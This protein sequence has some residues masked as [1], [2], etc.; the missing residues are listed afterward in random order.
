MATDIVHQW[1]A[2]THLAIHEDHGMTE[3]ARAV[4]Y[5][6]HFKHVIGSM[7]TEVPNVEIQSREQ[8]GIQV[9][10]AGKVKCVCGPNIMKGYY[11]NPERTRE[12]FRD[13]G[14]FRS[15]DV[16][17][18]GEGGLLLSKHYIFISF[19]ELT[20]LISKE[21][22]SDIIDAPILMIFDSLTSQIQSI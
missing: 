9:E 4:T 19:S 15:G 8:N 14:W 6:H 17:L 7:G 3:A 2:R 22:N 21:A 11:N 13:N 10:Q 18:L 20:T 1:K 12:A 16:G 5:N